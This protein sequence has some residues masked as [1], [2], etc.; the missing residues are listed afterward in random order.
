MIKQGSKVPKLRGIKIALLT[1]ILITFCQLK[2]NP[3]FIFN[4]LLEFFLGI[5]VVYLLFITMYYSMELLDNESSNKYIILYSGSIF[6]GRLS[7]T[8]YLYYSES[9]WPIFALMLGLLVFYLLSLL[10]FGIESPYYYFQLRNFD[11]ME[12]SL[13][14]ISRLNFSKEEQEQSMT[15]IERYMQEF[16]VI[17]ASQDLH[18]SNNSE[19]KEE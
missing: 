19:N 12:R 6:L 13:K 16:K 9:V 15:V 18:E 1:Q 3:T 7:I 11:S 4:L 10:A 2:M 17:A 5:S 14:E 8:F